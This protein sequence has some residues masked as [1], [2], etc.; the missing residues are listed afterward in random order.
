MAS[1]QSHNGQPSLKAAAAAILK[2]A[3]KSV[4]GFRDTDVLS[5]HAFEGFVRREEGPGLG[6]VALTS[7]SGQNLQSLIFLPGS[8]SFGFPVEVHSSAFS[9]HLCI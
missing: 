6:A 9:S 3:A 1:H 4:D 2:C 5:G 8:P 7:I